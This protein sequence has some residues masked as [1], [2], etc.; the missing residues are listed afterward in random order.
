[1][2]TFTSLLA[3]AGFANAY[4]SI[5]QH[6][7]EQAKAAA[8]NEKRQTPLSIPPFDAA[9]Q[10][11]SNQGD[12]KFV[13]PGPTDQRGPCPGLNAMAN[14]NYMPHNGIATIEQFIDGTEKGMC[15]LRATVQ[16]VANSTSSVRHVKRS[17]RIPGHLRCCRRRKPCHLEYW[18]S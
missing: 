11:V 14:H 8:P 7:S 1:M 15:I 17:R 9:A 12:H 2:K 10:Y 6:L 18:W 3:L 4:P 13:A 5:M 16:I